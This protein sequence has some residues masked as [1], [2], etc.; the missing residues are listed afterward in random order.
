MK[1]TSLGFAVLVVFA[2]VIAGGCPKDAPPPPPPPA[3]EEKAAEEKVAEEKAAVEKAAEEK[4]AEEAAAK[5]AEPVFDAS[6][7]P[8]ISG[9]E[10][11]SPDLHNAQFLIDNKALE[12]M[13][14]DGVPPNVIDS[15]RALEGK[16]F[17]NSAEFLT[18]VQGA[19]G[20]KALTQNRT[21]II[22]NSLAINLAQE[23][24]FP[25]TEL[26]LTA[27]QPRQ[28]MGSAEFDPVF[29]DFDRSQ[30]KPEFLAV[31]ERNA[32]VLMAKPQLKVIIEGHCDE[33]GTTQYNL[34]LGERRA[35]AVLQALIA[36]GVDPSRMETISF[37]EERPAASGQDE[38]AWAKNR[39]SVLT[40]TQ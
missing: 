33:R 24:P 40:I 14:S 10:G 9:L 4:V 28:V 7:L 6:K 15:L 11:A 22:R 35:N 3:A 19:I 36:L 23:P 32:K 8:R 34:A 1:G 21:S 25:G 18:A 16:I 26:G 29:F 12:G 39:R 17:S 5:A 2:A 30:I 31:I 13:A 20:E 37:G 38:A 27:L